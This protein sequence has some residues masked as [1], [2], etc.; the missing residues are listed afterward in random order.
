M[1]K[2]GQ[3]QY[4]FQQE[5][6]LSVTTQINNN[7]FYQEAQSLSKPQI[8]EATNNKKASIDLQYD[9][10]LDA[11][12]LLL[13]HIRGNSLGTFDI[14]LTSPKD[15]VLSSQTFYTF[16]KNY[17][18]EQ[19]NTCISTVFVP[20]SDFQELTWIKSSAFSLNPIDSTEQMD[21]EN[22]V[23]YKLKQLEG[24]PKTITKIGI[25]ANP[26]T[27]FLLNKEP[28]RVGRN[29]IYEIEGINISSIYVAPLTTGNL[30]IDYKYD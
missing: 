6:N 4:F 8:I 27:Y 28:I 7:S 13:F 11:P 18:V 3:A 16:T 23:L 29:G 14:Q 10:V 5:V 26:F 17:T 9:L 12:Y 30:I 24:L 20:Y 21:I 1:S 19:N 15:P 2:F 25:Q 22:V